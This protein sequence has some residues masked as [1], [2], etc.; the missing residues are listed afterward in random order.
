MSTVLTQTD[1]YTAALALPESARAELAHKLINS[2][3]KPPGVWSVD[4]ARFD[5]ELNR[6]IEELESGKVK[7]VAWSVI[8]E[9]ID[10]LL[11]KK[12]SN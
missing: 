8:R 4:D 2:L 1:L 7:G 12:R 6:R 9:E 3:D 10:E 5:D 11:R